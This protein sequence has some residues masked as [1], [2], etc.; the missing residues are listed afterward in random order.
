MKLNCSCS[1]HMAQGIALLTPYWLHLDSAVVYLFCID[2]LFALFIFVNIFAALF[3]MFAILP[4]GSVSALKGLTKSSFGFGWQTPV[5]CK[6]I[7]KQNAHLQ[8][9]E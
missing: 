4:F 9:A 8:K 6:T 2:I 7:L 5:P 1:K 3:A